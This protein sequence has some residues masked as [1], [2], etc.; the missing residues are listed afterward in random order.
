M[1]TSDPTR[2]PFLRRWR[3]VRVAVA[4]ESMRPALAPGDRL[5]VEWRRP[6]TPLP[7]VGEVVVV[8][9]PEASG[10]WLVKR[11]AAVGPAHVYV[12][13]RGV[14]VR[15]TGSVGDRPADAIDETAVPA[16]SVYVLSDGG[17]GGR[18]SRRFG[19]VP[20]E[21]LVGVAWWRYAPRDR[22]GPLPGPPEP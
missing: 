11:V 18:D 1:P 2:P 14:V 17:V 6:G 21:R 12:V 19:P 20:A 8:P 15:P 3:S 5:W 9:D 4:D 7:E 16:G 13:R 22:I 10:R